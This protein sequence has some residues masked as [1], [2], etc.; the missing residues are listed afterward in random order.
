MITSLSFHIP[1]HFARGV[2]YSDS[3]I[4]HTNCS[5]SVTKTYSYARYGIPIR[6]GDVYYYSLNEGLTPQSVYYA[7][8]IGAIN[9]KEKGKVFFDPNPLSEDGTISVCSP[10]TSSLTYS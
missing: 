9:S 8:D 10:H 5:C 2:F 6:S 3:V 4:I 1:R 7:L